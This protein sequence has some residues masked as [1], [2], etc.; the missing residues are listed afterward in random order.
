M[1]E[2]REK[3][4]RSHHT[5]LLTAQIIFIVVLHSFQREN[6]RM[7]LSFY[8]AERE[9]HTILKYKEVA[10]IFMQ[11]LPKESCQKLPVRVLAA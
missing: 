3:N 6:T 1:S 8:M 7:K 4:T 9:L 2:L 11:Y 5:I 10:I